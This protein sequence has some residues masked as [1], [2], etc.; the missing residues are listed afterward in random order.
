MTYLRELLR[1]ELTYLLA[2][3]FLSSVRFRYGLLRH[4]QSL[5]FLPTSF[6]HVVVAPLIQN[7][8]ESFTDVNKYCAIVLTNVNTKIILEDA[9]D[10]DEAE[11]ICW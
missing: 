9:V 8:C 11:Y 5:R 2:S 3:T 4:F 10:K 7:K 6:W 1:S